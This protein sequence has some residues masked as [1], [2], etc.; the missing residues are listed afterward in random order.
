MVTRRYAKANNPYIDGYQPEQPTTYLQYLDANNLYGWAMCQYLPA[1]VF[2]WETPT[3]EL[4]EQICAQLDDH[5]IGYMV[6]CD[7]LTPESHHDPFP[8]TRLRR[9]SCP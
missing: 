1:S 6:E 4:L 9:K 2:K 7:L 3:D 8:T 5:S